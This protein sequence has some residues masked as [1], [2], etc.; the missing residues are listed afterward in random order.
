MK[1]LYLEDDFNLAQTVE[2]F[3]TSEGFDVVC[4]HDGDEAL[5]LLYKNNFDLLL[6]DV[7]VPNI[8]GFEILK[9]LRDAD[10]K[11]P[12]IFTTSRNTIDDL[13]HGYSVGADDYLKK[14]FA[15]KELILRIKAILKR[16]Y[17]GTYESII[18]NNEILFNT[19]TQCIT[20]N[21]IK[22]EINNKESELLKLLLKNKNKCVDFEVIFENVWSYDSTHSEQSLRTYIKNLRKILGKDM[23]LSIKTKGYMLVA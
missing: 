6:L 23:I 15:L 21:N 3:L 8:N 17:H 4:V 22:H 14:P 2:E 18:I 16:E 10:V 11:T 5:E 19:N 20:K 13:S 9:L 1:I 12:A 7:Q